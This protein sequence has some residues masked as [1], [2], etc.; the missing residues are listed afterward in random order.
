MAASDRRM[1]GA[2]R[3][4][5]NIARRFAHWLL[6]KS[7]ALDARLARSTVAAHVA[8]Q[9]PICQHQRIQ[10]WVRE[11]SPFHSMTSSR[12]FHRQLLGH[13]GGSN[14]SVA[15]RANAAWKSCEEGDV[16][17]RPV[18]EVVDELCRYPRSAKKSHLVQQSSNREDETIGAIMARCPASTWL[19]YLKMTGQS[20]KKAKPLYAALS[21]MEMSSL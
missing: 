17:L 8:L 14:D 7:N 5:S 19:A 1:D 13:L 11:P 2:L 18:Q 9:P 4:C 6:L 12:D 3:L 15:F 21:K 10:H 16:L 20:P